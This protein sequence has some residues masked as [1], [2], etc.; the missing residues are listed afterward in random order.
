[1][2][3]VALGQWWI[4]REMAPVDSEELRA[5]PADD[6]ATEVAVG[7]EGPESYRSRN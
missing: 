1:M 6:I 3:R 5:V 4:I 7:P 2:Y